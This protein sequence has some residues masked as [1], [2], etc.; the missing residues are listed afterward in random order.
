MTESKEALLIQELDERV[1]N[2]RNLDNSEAAFEL[3]NFKEWIIEEL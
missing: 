3:E 1:Q 2:S